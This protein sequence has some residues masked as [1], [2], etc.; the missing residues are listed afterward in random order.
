MPAPVSQMLTL[1]SMLAEA[2]WQLGFD[3]QGAEQLDGRVQG[4]KVGCEI[5]ISLSTLGMVGACQKGVTLTV[6]YCLPVACRSG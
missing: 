3:V 5:S 1:F 4:T 2:A 6:S